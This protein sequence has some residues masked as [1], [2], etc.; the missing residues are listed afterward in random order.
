MK[1]MLA[2]T[3]SMIMSGNIWAAGLEQ[4]MS[5]Q[6]VDKTTDKLVKVLKEKGLTVFTVIDHMGNAGKVGL[7]LPPTKLVIFGNPK[8]GTK[9]MQCSHTTAIDLPQK[10]L[11]YQDQAGKTQI[12]YNNP[13]YLA[14]RH[15][16]K[17]CDKFISKIQGLLGGVAKA[18]AQ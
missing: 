9:L 10:Y 2:I 8:V 17:G 12:T 18:A 13:Q 1:K 14:D 11:V 16:M 15:K 6:N 4:V 7:K 5:N 3:F